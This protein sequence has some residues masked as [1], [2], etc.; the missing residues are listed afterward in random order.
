MW[1]SRS[2]CT[3]YILQLVCITRFVDCSI[4]LRAAIS[5]VIIIDRYQVHFCFDIFGSIHCINSTLNL[6][7]SNDALQMTKLLIFCEGSALSILFRHL[8]KVMPWLLTSSMISLDS[9]FCLSQQSF[10]LDWQ[11]WITHVVASVAMATLGEFLCARNE[12]QDIPLYT[13][14]N[15]NFEVA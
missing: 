6:P 14:P 12:L 7:S 5:P 3:F 13:R 11:W 8:L 4:H 9:L 10:P 15:G 1:T 2:L